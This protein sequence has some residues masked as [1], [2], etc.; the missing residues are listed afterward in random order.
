MYEPPWKQLE[1][2]K[3]M[4]LYRGINCAFR[5]SPTPPLRIIFPQRKLA[6][7]SNFFSSVFVFLSVTLRPFTSFWCN[8][9]LFPCSILNFSPG[10]FPENNYLDKVHHLLTCCLICR[11][12]F[13]AWC[14]LFSARCYPSDTPAM[15]GHVVVIYLSTGIYIF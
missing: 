2:K 5:S 1:N 9:L 13:E 15:I 10:I 4:E 8:Y 3:C 14:S 12:Y 11:L 6:T 7:R